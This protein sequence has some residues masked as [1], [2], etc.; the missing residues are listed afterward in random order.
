MA[1]TRDN[2]TMIGLAVPSPFVGS[3]VVAATVAAADDDEL[4]APSNIPTYN[5]CC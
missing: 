1:G 5:H 4:A 3:G 2:L